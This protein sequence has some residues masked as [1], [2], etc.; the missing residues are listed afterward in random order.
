MSNQIKIIIGVIVVILIGGGYFV[1]KR[2]GATT[3]TGNPIS[4]LFPQIDTNNSSGETPDTETPTNTENTNRLRAITQSPVAGYVVIEKGD[5]TI[6]RYAEHGTGYIYDY[7]TSNN[8]S[9]KISNETL[10]GVQNV[11]WA[12]DG[13]RFIVRS[14]IDDILISTAYAF[15]DKTAFTF[16]RNLIFG[17]TSADVLE[18]QRRLNDDP[19]TLVSQTGIGSPGN[20]T[21]RFGEGTKKALIKFQ[22]KYADD[23][24]TPQNLTKGSGL[25]DLA[26]REKLNSLQKTTNDDITQV[27]LSE[28]RLP[29]GVTQITISPDSSKIFY[30]SSERAGGVSGY[31]SAFDG[32]NPKKIYSSSFGDLV[33]FWN[34][35]ETILLTTKPS[36]SVVGFLYA[37][38][39]TT[40]A[41]VNMLRE[42]VG[43]TTQTSPHK[44]F[45][46]YSRKRPENGAPELSLYSK[47]TSVSDVLSLRTLPEKCTWGKTTL[48]CAVPSILPP[49]LYPDDWYKGKVSLSDAFWSVNQ[50]SLEQD[51][52]TE[53][54]SEVDAIQLRI[55]SSEKYI[56]FVNK[57]DLSLWALGI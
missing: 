45:I 22:E 28:K 39:P 18:L 38:N 14:L 55:N 34:D 20:E 15:Q 24:L 57:K 23:I 16:N 41:S 12:N 43:L 4:N 53:K 10:R 37:V 19:E 47:T 36:G 8:T 17:E 2:S 35:A 48:Y 29:L 5:K 51:A 30:L 50:S 49:A 42:I 44:D 54:L 33:P 11:L 7:D 27:T 31:V 13:N 6:I 9:V 52:I 21:T 46:A 56:Y 25:F 3:N 1:F 26:T 32:T 40:G